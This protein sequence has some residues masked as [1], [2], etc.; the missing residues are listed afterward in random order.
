MFLQFDPLDT[1]NSSERIDNAWNQD[2]THQLVV[3][4]A[5]LIQQIQQ[6]TAGASEE[7]SIPYFETCLAHQLRNFRFDD[8]EDTSPAIIPRSFPT[9]KHNPWH[10]TFLFQ[11]ALV[12]D[13]F[14]PILTG[15]QPMDILPITPP[16]P[17]WPSAENNTPMYPT[18]D[19]IK[20]QAK[21]ILQKMSFLTT[22][23]SSKFCYTVYNPENG[24]AILNANGQEVKGYRLGDQ[25]IKTVVNMVI[26]LVMKTYKHHYH[27]CAQERNE[28]R[29][30]IL[31]K[32]LS[33]DVVAVLQEVKFKN[34]REDQAVPVFLVRLFR[35][36]STLS[37]K[38]NTCVGRKLAELLQETS[39]EELM[40]EYFPSRP[41][42]A[43]GDYRVKRPSLCRKEARFA[44][45]LRN[46]C[47]NR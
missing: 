9:K 14:T 35:D 40:T 7:F 20:S 45:A 39:F 37:K 47:P 3:F 28:A 46:F 27:G 2:S 38:V 11:P 17:Q 13:E 26:D 21:P 8:L 18:A 1:A 29:N 43:P 4:C 10:Q 32:E 25:P 15:L 34:S 30:P 22:G 33:A 36:K 41:N 24:N 12:S 42:P 5:Q 31:Q 6:I 16:V 23:E 19:F 44:A